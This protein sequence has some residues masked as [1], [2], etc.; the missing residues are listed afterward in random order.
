MDKRRPML[1]MALVVALGATMLG[2]ASRQDR[3]RLVVGASLDLSGAD[4]GLGRAQRDVLRLVEKADSGPASVRV[5][6]ADNRGQPELA[7]NITEEFMRD[8]AV[9]AIVGGSTQV[10]AA[11]MAAVTGDKPMLLLASDLP[12]VDS[13]RTPNVFSTAPAVDVSADAVLSALRASS[14]QRMAVLSSRDNYGRAGAEEL[15]TKAGDFGITVSDSQSFDKDETEFRR[16]VA[17]T[18]D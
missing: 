10:T 11:V 3:L 16:S 6:F 1:T 17:A 15:T 12:S 4:G 8:G 2:C 14:L 5:I 18:V 7:R 9:N 13:Q